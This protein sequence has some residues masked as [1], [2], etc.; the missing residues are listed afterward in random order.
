[1]AK[2]PTQKPGRQPAKQRR[3]R[4]NAPKP[5]KKRRL[6]W[7]V[8][9][10]ALAL[11]LFVA[12][13]LHTI[14]GLAMS[15]SLGLGDVVVV[16]RVQAEFGQISHDDIVI[17]R[18]PHDR[19]Q[20]LTLRVLATENHSV[21]ISGN[22]AVLTSTTPVDLS[23]PPLLAALDSPDAAL[24][25]PGQRTLSRQRPHSHPQDH[26]L[27]VPHGHVFLIG[28]NR[29]QAYDSR[30][31]GPLPLAD[32]MGKVVFVIRYNRPNGGWLGQWF[33]LP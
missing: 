31:F 17:V 15:P 16:D 10:A 8:G 14:D 32:I 5:F 24:P 3:P 4:S 25:Q 22:Q 27:I 21:R 6:L 18:S 7:L 20:T 33:G 11:L 23:A 9:F 30:T 26:L 1:M 19:E 13:D 29:Q 2:A 12:L 28:D